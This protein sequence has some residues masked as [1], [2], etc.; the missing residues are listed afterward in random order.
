MRGYSPA[1]VRT[2]VLGAVA[3]ATVVVVLGG[4]GSTS[5][6]S[7]TGSPA[8]GTTAAKPNG[9]ASSA[10]SGSHTVVKVQDAGGQPRQQLRISAPEGSTQHQTMTV[11]VQTSGSVDGRAIPS[12]TAPTM[13]M[14][15]VVEVPDVDD[16][17]DLTGTFR[18][19]GLQV[20]GSGSGVEAMKAALAPLAKIHGTIRT[21]ASG[22]LLDA[23]FST[24]EDL[25]PTLRS[26]LDSM[27]QQLGNM[28]VP[29]PEVPVGT[30]ARWTVHTEPELGGIKAAVDYA[31]ELVG[32]VGDRLELKM[33]YVETMKDQDAQIP[34]LPAGATAHVYAS[35]VA[36]SGRMV[37]DLASLFPVESDLETRGP[38]HMLLSQ[39]AQKSDIVQNMH[40]RMKLGS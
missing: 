9:G 7:R 25:N 18:Y 19:D 13:K 5:D 17:G 39:G 35:K 38:V 1:M 16:Q 34:N 36:G 8:A 31:Y 14:G 23:R 3:C 6:G 40:M 37:L 33:S 26:L 4:C 22:R 27:K 10:P 30:G 28:M 32:R 20:L 21:T 11:Q 15:M 2:K 29:L 24:P 12:S